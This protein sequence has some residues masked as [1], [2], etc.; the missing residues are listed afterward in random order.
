MTPTTN[1][2]DTAHGVHA[3]AER[4]GVAWSEVERHSRQMDRVLTGVAL[5]DLR[6][7]QKVTQRELAKRLG[8]SQNRIS[9][10]EKGQ[11]DNTQIGTIRKY[12]E[13]LGGKITLDAT[14][15]D[16]VVPIHLG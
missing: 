10:I 16:T 3:L 9:K 14:F 7:A 15:G 5:H 1:N 13:A 8:V 6:K 11:F 12:I 2:T 4:L